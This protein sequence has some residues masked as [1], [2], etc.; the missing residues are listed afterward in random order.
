V[1]LTVGIAVGV[2]VR[3]G[4]L[5]GCSDGDGVAVDGSVGLAVRVA[6]SRVAAPGVIGDSLLQDVTSISIVIRVSSGK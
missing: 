5:L 4:V 3:V 6:V 1:G 2:G